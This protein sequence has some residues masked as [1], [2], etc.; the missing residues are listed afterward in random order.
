MQK[1]AKESLF[2]IKFLSEVRLSPDGEHAAFIVSNGCIKDNKY[3]NFIWIYNFSTA[4]IFKL[5]A[6]GEEKN[7]EWL[8]NENLIFPASRDEKEKEKIKK[9]LPITFYYSISIKGGEAEK[10]FEVPA[11]ASKLKAA[12]DD[13]FVVLAGFDN[14]MKDLSEMDDAGKE[15]YFKELGEANSAYKIFDE[16]PFWQ[17]GPGVTNKKRN[18]LYI[19]DEKTN[20]LK[21]ISAPLMNV[22]DWALEGSKVVFTGVEFDSMM[23]QK[24]QLYT[25]DL[26]T[27]KLTK[28]E[29][30]KDYAIGFVRFFGDKLVLSARAYDT[31]NSYANSKLY[32]LPLSGGVP[33]IFQ[34]GDFSIGNSVG[35]DC[36]YGGGDAYK[37]HENKFYYI[38]TRGYS[39]HLFK[40][41]KGEETQLS[42]DVTGGIDCFDLADGK[43]LYVAA[44]NK[45]LQEL[46]ELDLSTGAE[47]K[48]SDFNGEWLK[49]Y[50]VSYP[51]HFT[52]KN[53]D[54]VELDGFI[55]KPAGYEE[56]K[57]YPAILDIHGGPKATY[58]D[59]V[60]H[61]MQLWASGGY[62]VFYTNPR[63]SDGKGTE[64][65]NIVGER[66]VNW[67]YNDF[68][69]FTDKVLEIYPQIDVDNVGVTGGSYGGLMVNWMVG[70]TKRFKAAATQR[71]ITNFVSKC[72]T[73]DIGYYHN[74]DQI[75]TDPWTDYEA[76]WNK[77]P[78]KYADKVTT[79]L[80]FIHSDQDY[81]CYMADA[82]QM[83]T[84]LK[85]FGV[86]TRMC[87]FHGENHELSRSGKPKNR[88]K[89]L[90][91]ITGWFD[92]YLKSR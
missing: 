50:A 17:N 25:Y 66:Y 5:T 83:F 74:L 46:Y 49:N 18:R 86:D 58:G 24:S 82:F 71:S 77:S 41:E 70:H 26:N 67:D 91:E 7:I 39:S 1:I 13:K 75:G 38:S 34:E 8:D 21:A 22:I 87:L 90:E 62:F 76:F 43:C 37:I 52:F 23:V 80:L 59:I 28:I 10:I 44:R 79:P 30:D 63:G 40:S 31:I 20:S 88:L 51:E 73:T 33:E 45:G 81:R 92:K 64:F 6:S 72:L 2:D 54:G 55:I 60:Y 29:L 16:I 61:E 3:Q 78:L 68:M 15:K 27:E 89:R 56:G 69:D 35:S 36:K 14:N 47:K 85:M 11:K 57:K 12:C 48:V 9:G 84:A 4:H 65:A 42:P 32:T 19:F 53:R